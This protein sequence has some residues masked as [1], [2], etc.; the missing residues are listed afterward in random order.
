MKAAPMA[1]VEPYPS[2]VI[3]P[4]SAETALI[5]AQRCFSSVESAG[6]QP[7]FART[8]V[9]PAIALAPIVHPISVQWYTWRMI[10]GVLT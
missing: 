8:G 9:L 2:N 4:S 10:F 1:G 6:S 5:S 3:P 7:G